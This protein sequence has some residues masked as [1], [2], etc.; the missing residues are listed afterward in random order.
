M[1]IWVYWGWVWKN[2]HRSLLKVPITT[3]H[4]GRPNKFVPSKSHRVQ[5]VSTLRSL[6]KSIRMFRYVIF[7]MPNIV[8]V[9]QLLIEHHA[10]KHGTPETCF[11]SAANWKNMIF[12][13][14][15]LCFKMSYFKSKYAYSWCPSLYHMISLTHHAFANNLD[16]HGSTS[17][18]WIWWMF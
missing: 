6:G 10:F 17:D 8:P 5:K 2:I 18:I 4:T 11:F 1:W 9:W 12:W 13:L 14:L 15:L 3:N 16:H 7:T